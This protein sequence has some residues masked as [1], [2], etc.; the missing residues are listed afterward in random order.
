[1]LQL[2]KIG[3][4]GYRVTTEN[5][6]ASMLTRYGFLR[7]EL[8]RTY[9]PCRAEIT[10]NGVRFQSGKRDVAVAV[11]NMNGGG[12]ELKIPLR[13]KERL[14]GMGDANR[15]SVMIRG[16][17][18][19][20]WV[21]N[22]ASYGPMPVVLSSDGWAIIVNSTYYQKF[23]LGES[24]K[25]TLIISVTGGTAD[26]YLLSA[27]TLLDM[28]QAITDITGKPTMLPAFGYGLTFVES[29]Q[30]MNARQLLT[31]VRMMRDRGIPCDVFGLEPSWMSQHY[32]LSTEKEWDKE[33]FWMPHWL[34][35]NTASHRT[36]M[37]PMR[38]MGMQ[39]SLWLCED[40]DLF[41]EED[42]NEIVGGAI[43]Y[44][45]QDSDEENFKKNVDF[46]D[47]HIQG[48]KKLDVITKEDEPWFEHLKKF[49][50][51]GVACFKL[52]GYTQVMPHPDRLWAKKYLDNEVHNVYCVT[53]AK[54]MKEG[55]QKHTDRRGLI[56]TSGAYVG[57]QKYAA[58]WAGDT[59]GGPR[60]L[61]ACLNYA[62]CGHTN[63][64]CDMDILDTKAIHYAFL[65]TWTQICSWAYYFQPWFLPP[66]IEQTIKNYSLLRSSLFPYIYSAAHNASVSGIPVMRPLPML[67]SDT[68]HY[69]DVHNAYMLGDSLYV[70]A[71][72]MHLKLPEGEWV[73]YFTGKIYQGDVEYEIADGYAGALLVKKGSVFVTMEP[74]QYI[75]EKEHDYI[76]RVYTGG[77]GAFSL[78]EDDA[79][80]YDYEKGGYAQTRFTWTEEGTGGTLAVY[81]RQG[82]FSGRPNNGHDRINNSIPKIDGI[83]PVRDMAVRIYGK[84]PKSVCLGEKEIAFTVCD[85]YIEFT[86]TAD[87]HE[88]SDL[89]Y[90][91]A[92]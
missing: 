72:D 27:D 20:V 90:K 51:N 76:V 7:D 12:F 8:S 22:V 91:V 16:K 68:D 38:F 73:D 40:Y 1:M 57:T 64:T 60:T 29:E 87:L 11:K 34:P 63:T 92:Y 4:S 69:D 85:G 77:N 24:D 88:Q 30:L 44:Q 26:F 33:R 21:A 54:Q 55:F 48:V 9:A 32:D 25:D 41:Y 35:E 6:H 74:Q 84:T 43:E 28:V 10:E 67:Y 13:D 19:N 45:T 23:D 83:K 17:T 71:F 42:R 52:D 53:L 49:V 37:G 56:Y 2:K 36:F 79:F 86:V 18:L 82:D 3:E 14:F 61:V 80:T 62:M 31:D 89:F 46:A 78:Y 47:A 70:G 50:D 39:L 66:E 65:S 15:D 75:L 5:G 59:G 58:T 81:R